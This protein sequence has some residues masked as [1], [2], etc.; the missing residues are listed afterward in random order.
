[1]IWTNSLQIDQFLQSISR[2]DTRGVDL[3]DESPS[4]SVTGEQ[5]KQKRE[6]QDGLSDFSRRIGRNLGYVSNSAED[7]YY[8]IRATKDPF[9]NETL[10]KLQSENLIGLKLYPAKSDVAD[11]LDLSNTD[12]KLNLEAYIEISPQLFQSK[13][14][15]NLDTLKFIAKV[16]KET[17][18]DQFSIPNFNTKITRGQPENGNLLV[19]GGSKILKFLDGKYDK[20]TLYDILEANGGAGLR[21]RLEFFVDYSKGGIEVKFNGDP[22]YRMIGDFPGVSQLSEWNAEEIEEMFDFLRNLVGGDENKVFGFDPPEKRERALS[23]GEITLATPSD[24][25][26]TYLDP[27]LP[28]ETQ[29]SIYNADWFW[30]PSHK[31]GPRLILNGSRV[32]TTDERRTIKEVVE[33]NILNSGIKVVNYNPSDPTH[34][35]A[36]QKTKQRF[37][38]RLNLQ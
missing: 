10:E 18:I 11:F 22:E 5:E 33:S 34:L 1:M 16:A 12:R 17:G 23:I 25:F 2:Q 3:A 30:D 13:T 9:L 35:A 4:V 7:L 28:I 32:S 31:E 26:A 24:I 27:N 19:R 15:G 14:Q 29:R 6:I 36:E 37:Q 38:S 20:F 8:K 21:D